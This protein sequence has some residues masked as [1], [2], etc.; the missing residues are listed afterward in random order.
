[1]AEVVSFGFLSVTAFMFVFLKDGW[2]P[3]HLGLV[4]TLVGQRE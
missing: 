3:T 1:M 4:A 2:R